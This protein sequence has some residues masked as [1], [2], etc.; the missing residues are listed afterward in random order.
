MAMAAVTFAGTFIYIT[1][2]KHYDTLNM[3]SI[4]QEEATLLDIN[5]KK[6]LVDTG[7]DIMGSSLSYDRTLRE[8]LKNAG[9]DSLDIVFISHFDSDHAGNLEYLLYEFDVKNICFY[10]DIAPSYIKAKIID[11]GINYIDPDK[12]NGI[13]LGKE[14]YIKIIHR[15][16]NFKGN[17]NSL[18]FELDA[19]GT[20][21]LFTGDI[22]RE[23]EDYYID[24]LNKI[25]ILKV[26]HHGSKTSSSMNFLEK[27][28][29]KDAIS[30]QGLNNSYGHP[31]EETL[32]NFKAIGTNFY[33]TDKQGMISVI[34]KDG[35][36]EIETFYK[37]YYR[38]LDYMKKYILLLTLLSIIFSYIISIVIDDYKKFGDM[39]NEL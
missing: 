28:R 33:R 36:Y 4:G 11:R 29:P 21:V 5:K 13:D 18:V 15:D 6:I 32:E 14:N 7:G 24:K 12:T 39:I 19:G 37:E 31:H 1:S 17:S 30:S 20:K 16:E 9:A 35:G 38:H 34:F 3:I 8:V 25:D 27:T 10:K 23:A 22:E 26:A 2:Q